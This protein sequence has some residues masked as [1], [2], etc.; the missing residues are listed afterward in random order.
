MA[1]SFLHRTV[2]TRANYELVISILASISIVLSTSHHWLNFWELPIEKQLIV[3]L[4]GVPALT[5]FT[6]FLLTYIWDHCRKINRRRWLAFLFPGLIAVA[7]MTS[8]LFSVPV[9]WH[10]LEI[11]P[12][13]NSGLNEIQL[14]EIKVPG[15]VVQFSDL[16]YLTGWE[17]RNGVLVTSSPTPGFIRYS[18]LSPI[19][20]PVAFTF[21]TSHKSGN[22][23]LILDG[24]KLNTSLAGL[25]AGQ[26]V[27]RMNTQYRLGIPGTAIIL[28]IIGMDLFCFTFLLT[29]AWVVQEMNQV[30]ERTLPEKNRD[31]FFTHRTGLLVLIVIASIIHFINFLSVPL[32][33]GPDSPGYLDGSVYWIQHHTLDGVSAI[34]GP[35]STFLF[36]PVM[37]LFGMNPWGM[38][39]LLHLFAIACIPV[40][41]RLGW[42]LSKQ[43]WFAFLAGLIAVLTPDL[44]FYSNYVMSD[45]P[46]AFLGLL[47]CTLLLSALETF[48]WKWLITVALVGSFSALFRS[49]N[50]ASLILG[51]VFLLLKILWERKIQGYAGIQNQHTREAQNR[52]WRLGLVVLLA[53]IPILAWSVHNYRHYGFFGLSNYGDEVLYDGWVYYGES[54]HVD[55]TDQESSAVK[56]IKA[57]YAP[58]FNEKERPNIPTG[59]DIYP[60]LL[61]HGYTSE[62]AF[63]ML[64]QAAKDSIRK[65]I[66]TTLKLL[67]IKIRKGMTPETISFQ[68]T[69]PLPSDRVYIESSASDYFDREPALSPSAIYMQRRINDQLIKWYQY[70]YP[71][72]V[73]F[74]L[75]MM[76]L[77]L[78][79]KPFFVW[80]PIITIAATH[81]FVPTVIGMSLWRYVISGIVLLQIFAL[82]GL[83]PLMNFLAVI[84]KL[85]FRRTN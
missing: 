43:R 53:A 14:L 55:I 77:C 71:G 67:D 47:F 34:R 40:S 64:G 38:K 15:R 81:I 11:V 25:Q 44:I 82:T 16:K 1:S 7:G 19:N 62:Q 9:V 66:F 60:S 84:S 18:F 26:A 76:L 36:L 49:E 31:L 27:I 35:G 61:E 45:L 3:V 74:S 37:L 65:N 58:P 50:I 32:I 85:S 59:W 5:F 24:E 21:L 20:N 48:S 17:I 79:R 52:L 51:A 72:W 13:T 23:T 42:Q 30:P 78:Y 57:A 63:L 68:H 73:W 83:W 22:V 41:Y 2:K 4:I 10:N 6:W 33:I 39:L 28:I 56:A 54:S 75:G 80:V 70:V 12:S 8:Y 69:F 29:L 46:N